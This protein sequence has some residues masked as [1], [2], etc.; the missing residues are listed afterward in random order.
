MALSRKWMGIALAATVCTTF[1][2]PAVAEVAIVANPGTKV[3]ALTVDEVKDYWLGKNPAWPDGTKAVVMDQDESSKVR[4]DFYNAVFFKSP[5]QVKAFWAR[6]VFTGKGTAP[7]T[8]RDNAAIKKWVAETPGA[9]GYVD[10][11]AVDGSVKVMIK[12]K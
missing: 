1:V 12:V 6:I 11:T 5:S 2:L 3:S 9:L 4:D 7:Q 8:L 10:A